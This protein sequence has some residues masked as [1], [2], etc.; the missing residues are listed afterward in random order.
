ME[1]TQL[2]RS[3]RDIAQKQGRIGRGCLHHILSSLLGLNTL[4]RAAWTSATDLALVQFW[5]PIWADWRVTWDNGE[6]IFLTQ[7][8]MQP[9]FYLIWMH[10]RLLFQFGCSNAGWDFAAHSSYSLGRETIFIAPIWRCYHKLN[11]GASEYKGCA[12]PLNCSP[13][14]LK[15]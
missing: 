6:N 8:G 15:V 4:H 7:G 14:K 13:S 10:C 5:Y 2:P 12:L 11:L 1:Q 9:A 3:C